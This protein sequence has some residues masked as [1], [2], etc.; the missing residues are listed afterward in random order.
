MIQNS[1][2][3]ELS[4]VSSVRGSSRSCSRGSSVSV[5]SGTGFHRPATIDETTRKCV[6]LGLPNKKHKH[7]VT[8]TFEPWKR[9]DDDDDDEIALSGHHHQSESKTCDIQK[10]NRAIVNLSSPPR[11]TPESTS[12]SQ[13][14]P[15][16]SRLNQNKKEAPLRLRQSCFDPVLVCVLCRHN[17]NVHAF[18]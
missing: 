10:A 16:A 17:H 18:L 11:L 6:R 4:N 9:D 5:P 2:A 13:S 1:P 15:K 7:L 12:G 3:L 14:K 8:C